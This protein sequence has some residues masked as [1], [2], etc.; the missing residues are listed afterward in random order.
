MSTPR[1]A[2]LETAIDAVAAGLIDSEAIWTTATALMRCRRH[3]APV[4]V[5]DGARG[6]LCER[7]V[8]EPSIAPDRARD[9]QGER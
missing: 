7:C 2:A 4:M 1:T 8:I 5:F 3:G 9:Q 6:G